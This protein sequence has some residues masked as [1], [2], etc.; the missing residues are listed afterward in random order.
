MDS[1]AVI[2]RESRHRWEIL[3]RQSLFARYKCSR[4]LSHILEAQ[5]ARTRPLGMGFNAFASLQ[6]FPPLLFAS[7]P[8]APH[9]SVS[10][11]RLHTAICIV[12][13]LPWA[14]PRLAPRPIVHVLVPSL[15][16]MPLQHLAKHGRIP[17]PDSAGIASAGPSLDRHA[18]REG[19]GKLRSLHDQC[20][21]RDEVSG[22]H[23]IASPL[24]SPAV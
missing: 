16:Q 21:H 3:E 13:T 2:R 7:F 14:A 4:S 24:R 12:G 1:N 18:G 11:Q 20:K 17:P 19:N 15:S 10:V 9:P 5:R 6:H 23:I 8:I 22:P